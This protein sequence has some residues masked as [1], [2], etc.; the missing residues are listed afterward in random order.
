LAG[1]PAG[2]HDDQVDALGLIGQ[3][4]DM[5][6]AGR[7]PKRDVEPERDAYVERLLGE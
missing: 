3:L 4:L 7:E 6:T 1:V 2:K 5:M